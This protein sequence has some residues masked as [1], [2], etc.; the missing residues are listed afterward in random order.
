MALPIIIA[1][2][3]VLILARECQFGDSGT[4][5]ADVPGEWKI[6]WPLDDCS[7]GPAFLTFRG[8]LTNL[9]A[10]ARAYTV[11]VEFLTDEQQPIEAA[12]AET[13]VVG[14]GESTDLSLNG[15]TSPQ[16][17]SGEVICKAEAVAAG[18]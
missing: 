13:G 3:L 18:G 5:V 15:V 1:T 17:S 7:G 9:S 8:E 14:P 11:T 10:E 12:T 6:E 2:I 4:G 16:P